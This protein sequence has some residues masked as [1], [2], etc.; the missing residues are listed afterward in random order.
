MYTDLLTLRQCFQVLFRK[1][2]STRNFKKLYC[3]D[4]FIE[5][6]FGIFGDKIKLR[7]AKLEIKEKSQKLTKN[8]F[9]WTNIFFYK[10]SSLLTPVKNLLCLL[11]LLLVMQITLKMFFR[12]IFLL[13]HLRFC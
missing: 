8:V 13:K 10:S 12:E 1:V 3:S 2:C 11:L 6:E 9:F 4:V 5:I 7:K